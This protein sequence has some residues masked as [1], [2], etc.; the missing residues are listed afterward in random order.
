MFIGNLEI[1]KF[2]F[3]FCFEGEFVLWKVICFRFFVVFFLWDYRVL[4]MLGILEVVVIVIGE[5]EA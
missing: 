3:S 2:F 1:F 5:V 4:V